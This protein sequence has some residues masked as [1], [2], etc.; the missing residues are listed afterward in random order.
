MIE[1]P[2]QACGTRFRTQTRR[3]RSKK[4]FQPNYLTSGNWR[5]AWRAMSQWKS[6]NYSFRKPVMIL[7]IKVYN[8]INNQKKADLWSAGGDE[9]GLEDEYGQMDIEVHVGHPRMPSGIIVDLLIPFY[10]MVFL[11]ER[12]EGWMVHS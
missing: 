2:V 7:F 6:K 9:F 4:S 8:S 10:S 5:V 1:G 3:V 11:W 12:L